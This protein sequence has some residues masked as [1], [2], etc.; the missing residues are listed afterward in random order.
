MRQIILFDINT[1]AGLQKPHSRNRRKLKQHTVSPF[2]GI[3]WADSWRVT[4]GVKSLTRQRAL[5]ELTLSAPCQLH[6][7]RTFL[8]PC[9]QDPVPRENSKFSRKTTLIRIELLFCFLL[10]KCCNGNCLWTLQRV[11]ENVN[12]WIITRVT[13][14]EFCCPEYFKRKRPVPSRSVWTPQK[15]CCPRNNSEQKKM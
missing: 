6:V 13:Y 10:S 2:G 4:V 8:K 7:R 15:L 5:G 12:D 1:G 9:Q 11:Y 3:S 14:I